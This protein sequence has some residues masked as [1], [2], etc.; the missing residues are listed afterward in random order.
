MFKAK[1]R[2]LPTD[3]QH[4]FVLIENEGRR[5]GHF[6]YQT[7]RKTAKQMCRG[8]FATELIFKGD[9]VVEYRGKLLSPQQ[10][11]LQTI[12]Y[13]ESAKVFLFDFHWKSKTWCIDACEEDSSLG[14]LVNDDHRRPNCKMKTIKVNEN[15]HLCLFAI[16]DIT[17]GEEL[18]Y[19]YGDSNWAWRAQVSYLF[20]SIS[21]IH[22]VQHA[23]L[24]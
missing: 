19:N 12:E 3:L 6:R 22:P 4:L 11:E 13:N 18:T 5:K 1:N 9:F 15:P 7:V 2:V 21:N 20:I 24:R 8:V 17:A 16:R 14:R 23:R 10:A